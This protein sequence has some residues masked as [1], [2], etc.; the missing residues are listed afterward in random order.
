M[1]YTKVTSVTVEDV[2]SNIKHTH[3]GEEV[4]VDIMPQN[5][6]LGDYPVWSAPWWTRID[7]YTYE[8]NGNSEEELK[9]LQRIIADTPDPIITE[10][11]IQ[12]DQIYNVRSEE[13][14]D[15]NE[16]DGEVIKVDFGKKSDKTF[17]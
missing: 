13:I 7:S 17:H 8:A 5:Y 14:S 3:T 11:D 15:I 9:E 12:L 10:V 16:E 6:N 1:Q 2:V 4:N